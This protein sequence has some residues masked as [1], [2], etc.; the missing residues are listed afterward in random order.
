MFTSRPPM[1]VKRWFVPGCLKAGLWC[2]IA[3]EEVCGNFHTID[4]SRQAESAIHKIY[5]PVSSLL[6]NINEIFYSE[7]EFLDVI[8]TKGLGV[9]LLLTHSNCTNGFYHLSI[10]LGNPNSEAS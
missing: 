3:S 4:D 8:G 9:F 7:A 5:K 10:L 6:H 1:W 2:K